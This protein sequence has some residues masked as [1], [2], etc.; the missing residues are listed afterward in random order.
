MKAVTAAEMRRI[1]ERAIGEYGIPG[2][3]LMG[4][5]GRV[6]ANYILDN[7]RD[8]RSAA[9]FCG[10]GN[11]GGDGFVIAWLL[12]NAGWDVKVFLAG[13]AEKL[14]VSAKIY[15]DICIKAA[16]PVLEMADDM[17]S[18]PVDISF[19][20]VVVDALLGTGFTGELRGAATG[21][22][23]LINSSGLPVVAVD[24]P[25]GLPSDGAGPEGGAVM[26]DVTV[27]MGLPKISLV[28]Y[29]GKRWTGKLV[30][31]EIGF[32]QR[33]T[34]SDDIKTAMIDADYVSARWPA[35]RDADAHKNSSGH[36]LLVGGFDGM[37]GAL[38]LTASA[39]FE[40]G[41]GLVTAL[42][43]G[44]ARTVMAGKI[45]EL[46]TA[47]IPGIESSGQEVPGEVRDGIAWN[48]DMEKKL[49][50]EIARDLGKFFMEGRRYGVAVVGPGMGRGPLSK[51]VF[52]ALMG[53]LENFGLA[54][55]IIDGDGLYHYAAWLAEKGASKADIIITPH[56]LEA[57]RITGDTVEKLKAN[58]FASAKALASKCGAVA[59]L[60]GPATLVSDGVNTR[61][62]TTGNPALATAGSGD[63][64]TGIIA[65]LASRGL[66]S[67]D[68]ASL[69]A[70]LHGRA[71]DL[72]VS[73][74]GVEVM[75][76]SDIAAHIRKAVA[77][78]R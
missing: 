71:A 8:V 12:A 10:C 63:V 33:L 16:L 41:A 40:T 49:A 29:P 78:L 38:L 24:V 15:H 76:A 72:F 2:E 62:N 25:S 57:S 31:A 32:P 7:F 56:F 14:S 30:L 47:A 4:Y 42:T 5:A 13:A 3:L 65:S 74:T 19:A 64:L 6:A 21:A 27:T 17:S 50:D 55:V 77:E 28:T 52:R 44:S 69:G 54:R 36:V 9:V 53:N 43:T 61:I 66:S 60:K 48:G 26:A 70:W 18:G 75:K 35:G 20:G 37:E 59:L 67:L 51:A 46:M 34:E 1:D 73:E 39:C 22:V 58:R 23:A 45:P 68:A 11:N